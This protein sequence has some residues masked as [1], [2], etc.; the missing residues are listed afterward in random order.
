MVCTVT[1]RLKRVNFVK[2]FPLLL[3]HAELQLAEEA[4]ILVY[5]GQSLY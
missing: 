2:E 5:K 3:L 4:R 1:T